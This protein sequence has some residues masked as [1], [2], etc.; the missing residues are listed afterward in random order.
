MILGVGK[1]RR[2]SAVCQ[3]LC[4]MKNVN[5]KWP[6]QY[7]YECVFFCTRV[8]ENERERYKERMIERGEIKRVGSAQNRWLPMR[9][10]AWREPAS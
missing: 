3:I 6:N 10:R 9:R 4:T 5:F 7:V 8:E 2:P 1:R